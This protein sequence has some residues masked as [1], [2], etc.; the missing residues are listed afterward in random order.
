VAVTAAAALAATAGSVA[1]RS[2]GTV[3]SLR[4]R[5]L[6]QRSIER[7]RQDAPRYSVDAIT[8]N[9]MSAE[10]IR[11]SLAV[12]R[13]AT[14][15][16]DGAYSVNSRFMGTI[17]QTRT[18]DTC[19]LSGLD[20]HGHHGYIE[21]AT[22]LPNPMAINV[23]VD[24]LQSICPNC[25]QLLLPA[26]MRRDPSIMRYRGMARIAAIARYVVRMKS[27]TCPRNLKLADAAG[28]DGNVELAHACP[29]I[30]VKYSAPSSPDDWKI[31][32]TVLPPSGPRGPRG[33]RNDQPVPVERIKGLF[34]AMTGDD[35]RVLGFS[36]DSH[37]RNMIIN[38]LPVIPECNRPRV[39][40]DGE[41][42]HDHLTLAYM[43]IIR[44]N[45][46]VQT[47]MAAREAGDPNAENDL[48]TA[49][50]KLYFDISHLMNN[51][52][53]Q[54]KLHKEDPASTVGSR[55]A[56]KR[57]LCRNTAQG[58]R[59]DH[60]IRTVIGP[61]IAPFGTVVLPG[62]TRSITIPE[63]ACVYNLENLR[64]LAREGEIIHLTRARGEDR[65]I[66][67]RY[68][69][70]VINAAAREEPFPEIELGDLVYRLT[71]NGDDFFINRQPSLHRHS[72]VGVRALF[73]PKKLTV[74]IHMSNTSG[75][76]ADFDG[77]EINCAAPQTLRA[78]AELRYLLAGTKQITTSA[79]SAPVAGLV[80]TA[81]IAAYLMCRDHDEDVAAGRSP[82]IITETEMDGLV[83][84]LLL[85]GSR[86]ATLPARLAA[87]GVEPLSP[88][89]IFSLALP[90]GFHYTRNYKDS[91]V[92]RDDDGK[93]KMDGDEAATRSVKRRVLIANGILIEGVL[94][95]T[96]VA[97]GIVHKLFL[98]FGHGIAQRFISEGAFILD[99][100]IERRGFSMNVGDVIMPDRAG[101]R[102]LVD[103][104]ITRVLHEVDVMMGQPA[105]TAT[106][107]G[108]R[109]VEIRSVLATVSRV[110]AFI[111]SEAFAG[112][113]NSLHVMIASGA[114]GTNKNAA[115]I[116]GALGQQFIKSE[117]AKGVLPGGRAS[118]Y[119]EL[120]DKTP[121]AYGFVS[122]SFSDG[123]SPSAFMW[124]MMASRLGL[125]DT[126]IHTA[127][128]GSLSHRTR[129]VLEN[130]K[131]DYFGA[132]VNSTGT[133]TSLSYNNGYSPSEQV[134]VTSF[135][136]TG[137]VFLPLD[138]RKLV[139]ELNDEFDYDEDVVAAVRAN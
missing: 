64:R 77:D 138:L 130:D 137:D 55:L 105:L 5:A 122:E 21:L 28:K 68:P 47:L 94:T 75:L 101:T 14:A 112:A 33:P 125:L 98:D 132:V 134:L 126:A 119:Y 65:D 96:D 19:H 27:V 17:D 76:N 6:V 124:H 108:H 103:A 118:P 44:D 4:E 106:A 109:E 18:C 86:A 69:K 89:A 50:Y 62:V 131:V 121:P 71:R 99:W 60:V 51:S 87:T 66:R 100:Y 2:S 95:K 135:T 54:L 9:F 111:A 8:F 37:P 84:G 23:I 48:C 72:I 136:S 104:K 67:R 56:G 26:S 30:C 120:Y 22:P 57:G 82:A 13:C 53:G 127:D 90:P 42:K 15:D 88:R 45:N 40:R 92:I 74:G 29:E 58:K 73:T 39:E 41:A 117:R 128:T 38:A 97:N 114:K 107:R 123:L 83:H 91:I 110:G 70:M 7:F 59:G 61:A 115:Q 36:D 79:F 52:D 49:I 24:V 34:S 20:C 133:F 3:M 85:D 10:F 12:I 102:R 46:N 81:P 113:D 43:H 32:K 139:A 25:A 31:T 116:S 78:R 129:K 1:A 63:R 80:F 93:I 16:L 35:L 11:D